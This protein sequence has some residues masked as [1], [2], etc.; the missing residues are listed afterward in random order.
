M[1]RSVMLHDQ[2]ACQTTAVTSRLSG[3]SRTYTLRP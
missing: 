3:T 1:E 2:I